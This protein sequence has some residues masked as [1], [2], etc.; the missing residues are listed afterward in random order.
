MAPNLLWFF[1]G[2][3]VLRVIKAASLSATVDDSSS[4]PFIRLSKV[5]WL[6]AWPEPKHLSFIRWLA[7]VALSVVRAICFCYHSKPSSL[8]TSLRSR[9]ARNQSLWSSPIRLLA[10]IQMAKGLFSSSLMLGAVETPQLQERNHSL[11]V[12]WVGKVT[13]G[14]TCLRSEIKPVVWNVLWRFSIFE[15]GCRFPYRIRGQCFS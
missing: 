12:P 9:I 7:L 5:H 1:C 15:V 10:L 3:T 8:P 6:P 13:S 2:I 4:P 14:C 11:F